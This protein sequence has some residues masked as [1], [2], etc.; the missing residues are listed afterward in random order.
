MSSKPASIARRHD[1]DALRAIAMLLG[2]AL[3][4]AIA[5]IPGGEGGWPVKDMHQH[6]GFGVFMAAIHGFRMPLFFLVSG[7]FTAMLWRKRG[8]PALIKHRINRILLPL[9][10]GVFTIVPAVFVA[11]IVGAIVSNTPLGADGAGRDDSALRMAAM[12]GDVAGVTQAI[13]AG[14]DV[15]E[16]FTMSRM[17]ALHEAALRGH[18]EVMECL[19]DADAN[20]NQQSGD[21]GTPLH[22]AV[23]LGRAEATEVL[24]DR[25]AD[26]A[27]KNDKGST[28][29]E[30]A[31]VPWE[32][33][34]WVSNSLLGI[35]LDRA[36]WQTGRKVCVSLLK[37]VQSGDG[38]TDL[39]L[40][41]DFDDIYFG[42]GESED[43][44]TDLA[45]TDDEDQESKQ[46]F[47]KEWDSGFDGLIGVFVGVFFFV[48]IFHHL[49]FLWFL[50]W[51]V[52]GFALYA[53]VSERF[54]WQGA[55]DWLVVSPLRYAW[56]IPLTCLP[57]AF[58]GLIYPVYGPD[59]S[60]GLLPMPHVLFYYAIFFG[61]GALYFDARDDEGKVG[62]GWWLSL[63]ISLLILFPLGSQLTVGEFG[64][65]AD[66][67]PEQWQRPLSVLLQVSYAWLMTFGCMGLFRRF[68]SQ[69]SPTMRYLSDSSYWL[70]LA[71]LPLVMLAHGF[72]A[73]VEIPALAKFTIITVGLSGLLLL[74]YEYLVRYT[75]IGTM[76]NGP[77]YRP[78]RVFEAVSAEVRS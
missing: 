59:T 41:G 21:G 52:A 1:L 48:P 16:P 63:P 13:E 61:Y 12:E 44:E 4:A 31:K 51:L 32:L 65:G 7:F 60:V 69:E 38:A 56:L 66:A 30:V 36:E 39:V 6:A 24:L 45:D 37:E 11:A 74:S 33:T 43:A 68:M 42:E 55:P 54:G 40:E 62:S 53:K 50:C 76:L 5:Y 10:V 46:D 8:L 49:W 3:H 70:Y 27:I 14:A 47:G 29:T 2:I 64:F 73:Q 75:F 9:G 77:R 58:M 34:S 22:L 23:F 20:P 17:T 57:Q 15:N 28:A 26:V 78:K 25:G 67:I 18:T 71:H 19:L 35:E 72:L